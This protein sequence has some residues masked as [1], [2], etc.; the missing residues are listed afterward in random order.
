MMAPAFVT[1]LA[2]F[3]D[4][5]TLVDAEGTRMTYT[6]RTERVEERDANADSI[7][8][9]LRGRDQLQRNRWEGSLLLLQRSFTRTDEVQS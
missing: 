3:G 1:A 5:I 6:E 4:R 7:A 2:Q 9:C 8:S